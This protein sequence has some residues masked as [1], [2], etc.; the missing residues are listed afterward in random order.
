MEYPHLNFYI[1]HDDL[2]EHFTLSQDERYLLSQWRKDI[3]KIGFAVLLKSF[4]YLG[5]PPK[6]KED[7]PDIIISFICGQLE[8]KTNLFG[9][10]HWK[11]H[12]VPEA[13]FLLFLE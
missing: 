11:N 1:T 7:I 9:T 8:I 4:Q 3:N 2:I 10:Y 12:S 6:L 5:Y 13:S